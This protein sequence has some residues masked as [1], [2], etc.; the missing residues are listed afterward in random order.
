MVNAISTFFSNIENFSS[1]R[2]KLM[3]IAASYFLFYV[4]SL[5]N[6]VLQNLPLRSKKILGIKN[7]AAESRTGYH[8]VTFDDDYV[9]CLLAYSGLTLVIFNSRSFLPTFYHFPSVI[10]S[11]GFFKFI[12]IATCAFFQIH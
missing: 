6:F 3:S 4:K 5:Q 10:V 1:T 7:R 8:G 9:I 2:K 11:H 12:F